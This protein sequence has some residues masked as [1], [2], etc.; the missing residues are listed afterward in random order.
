MHRVAM[1]ETILA[2]YTCRGNDGGR[3]GGA[4]SLSA[5]MRAKRR[6]ARRRS[7]RSGTRV[8]AGWAAPKLFRGGADVEQG[9]EKRFKGQRRYGR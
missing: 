2:I 7:G 3:E 5:T 1:D 4:S 6:Q 9:P 8:L